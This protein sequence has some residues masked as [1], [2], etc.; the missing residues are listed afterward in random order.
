MVDEAIGELV[1]GLKA[2]WDNTYFVITSDHG[3]EFGDRGDLSM[4]IHCWAL[5]PY[6]TCCHRPE[7]ARAYMASVMV[8]HVDLFQGLLAAGGYFTPVQG[9]GEDSFPCQ[10]GQWG[11]GARAPLKIF[12]GTLL[13]HCY[14]RLVITKEQKWNGLGTGSKGM[15]NRESARGSAATVGHSVASGLGGVAGQ[16]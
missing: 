3:E 13:F 12:V 2:N 14:R 7:V 1:A 9:S 11:A 8:E 16:P 15:G 6:P 5:D 10:E 4:A